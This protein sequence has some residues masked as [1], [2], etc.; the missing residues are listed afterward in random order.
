MVCLLSDIEL[1]VENQSD[2]TWEQSKASKEGA[3]RKRGGLTTSR[4]GPANPSQ[5][6]KPAGVDSSDEEIRHDAPLRLNAD[7]RD[8]GETR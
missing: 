8:Q 7:A 2:T 1:C 3:G 5:R 6:L 4:S